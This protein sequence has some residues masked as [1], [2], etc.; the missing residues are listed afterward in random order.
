MWEDLKHCVFAYIVFPCF[1]SF[2]LRL[3]LH[4]D[5]NT[6]TVLQ[7]SETLFIS[8]LFFLYPSDK[9]M[10]IDP[11]SSSPSISSVISNLPLSLSSD[12]FLFQSSCFTLWNFHFL[13]FLFL[14]WNSLFLH[15]NHVLSLNIFIIAALKYFSAKSISGSSQSQ[16]L[17]TVCFPEKGSHHSA[18][19]NIQKSSSEKWMFKYYIGGFLNSLVLFYYAVTFPD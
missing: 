5:Q 4:S 10:P 15:W 2:F 16:C 18:S 19:L 9:I 11:S 13:Y 6:D 8:L 1:S 7:V 17:L 12:F 3:Q 14:Y